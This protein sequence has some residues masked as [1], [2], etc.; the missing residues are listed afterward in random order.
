MNERPPLD[1][2]VLRSDLADVERDIGDSDEGL[3]AA[4]A[5]FLLTAKGQTLRPRERRFPIAWAAVALAASVALAVVGVARY[6]ASAPI[7]FDTG[8]ERIA[9]EVGTL[10]SAPAYEPLP[11]QFSDG[12]SVSMEAATRARVTETN[13]L[14]ATVVLEEGSLRVAVVH[15][16]T[17]RW[18]VTAGPFTILVT[19]TKFDVRWSSAEATLT[20]D[21]HDGSV[22]VLGPSLGPAGR[23]VFPGESL[24]VAVDEA[25]ATAPEEPP[26]GAAPFAASRDD[27]ARIGT[28]AS[29]AGHVS[30]KQLA[31]GGRYADALAAAEAEGFDAVCRHA[32]AADLVLL[33]DA[34]RFA[35]SPKRAQQAHELVRA[36]APG[37]HEAAMSAFTLGRIA[38]DRRTYRDAAR[39]FESYLRE[40]P[41][42]SLAREAAG[43]LIEAEKAA[44]DLAAARESAS[45]YL[46]KY[47]A[48]PHAGLARTILNQ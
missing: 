23:R 24:R 5:R 35:G 33:G 26:A 38:Y 8:A 39:W 40:D 48:G 14:G 36:R 30:W 15:R 42:G 43:R 41:S 6:R 13:A 44:G 47:P 19:G 16:P 32:S 1:L 28:S 12:T 18:H 37:T 20:L 4:R 21:L 9:G 11:V 17:T 45:A 46:A 7:S 29:G 3:R 2:D 31:Q 10:L 22:T 25:R 27:G 34:A